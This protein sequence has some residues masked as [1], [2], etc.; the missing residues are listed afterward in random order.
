MLYIYYIKCFI[1]YK[2]KCHINALYVLQ[3]IVEYFI[4]NI[5]ETAMKFSDTS[6]YT[7]PDWDPILNQDFP[8]LHT[9]PHL[10]TNTSQAL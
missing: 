6:I 9:F 1:F 3:P 8:N 10:S 4:S 7:L 5:N 2:T